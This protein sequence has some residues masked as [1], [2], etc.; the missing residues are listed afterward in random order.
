MDN[1]RPTHTYTF[2][3]RRYMYLC[4]YVFYGIYGKFAYFVYSIVVMSVVNEMKIYV[5]MS[6]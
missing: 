4:M 1:Q 2:R 5:D 6:I 3:L